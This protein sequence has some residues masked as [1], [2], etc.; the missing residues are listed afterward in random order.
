MRVSRLLLGAALSLT[1][2]S[3]AGAAMVKEQDRIRAQAEHDCYN[4]AQTLC[5]EAIPDEDKITACFTAK[6]P[7]LSPAC[8]KIFDAGMKG[9]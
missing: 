3:T 7:K 1:V 6:R 9:K 4:D 5:P 8:G 2:A